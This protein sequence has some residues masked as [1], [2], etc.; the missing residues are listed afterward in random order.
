M[1]LLAT[2]GAASARGF[3]MLASTGPGYWIGLLG[4]A[5]LDFA[6]SVAVDGSGNVY[7]CGYTGVSSGDFQIAK[8][9]AFGTI[10]WQRRLGGTGG[11]DEEEGRGIAV[12]SSGNVYVCGWSN[13][14]GNPDFQIAKYNTSGVIQWQRRLG[15]AFT[16]EYGSS[17]AVDGS[18]NVYVCG[19]GRASGVSAEFQMA[20]YDT[21]GVIQWQRRLGS[22]SSDVANSVAV[23]ISGNVYVCGFS[24]ASGN[25]DIQLAKYNT[26]GGIQWQ[27][28][29]GGTGEQYGN[30]IAV[31]G[32]GNI[33]ICGTAEI[34]GDFNFQIAKYDTSGNIQWQRSL[35]AASEEGR[36]VAV[37]SSGNVYVC[38]QSSATGTND[39]QIAKYNT[40][41]AIQWQRRLGGTGA[42][43]GRA[44]AVDSIGNVYVA[45]QSNAT[46][47]TDFLFAKL[48]GDGTLTG[49]YT[50]GGASF[51]YAASSLTDA[52]TSLTDTSTSL[53]DT[54]TSLT[55]A[56]SSLTS[57][58]TSLTSSVTII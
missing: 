1:P 49:T 23:D 58:T 5:A 50:V 26:S 27:R 34:S 44:V 15:G 51:T 20:K 46:G 11:A 55:D 7:L 18:G 57:P 14:S 21:S 2:R 40:S 24:M 16:D 9:N 29:L 48:P 17:I 33:Y 28:R 37:D 41:G 6:Q 8:Y 53:T 10:E 47:A 54:S 43:V 52:A 3:G 30:S 19:E 38:G 39:L 22:T 36:A 12:D 13:A 45:G 56:A 42:E 4:G 35:N 31:D 25:P 32:S